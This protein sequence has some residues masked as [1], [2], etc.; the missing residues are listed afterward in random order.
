MTAPAF[1]QQGSASLE[2][3]FRQEI[4][5]V[6]MSWLDAL[7]RGD[8]RAV[9][10]YYLPGAP[11]INPAGV[12]RADTRDYVNRIER[13]HQRNLKLTAMIDRVQ[14]IGSDAG[15]AVG[16]F[17]STF[18]TNDSRS[19]TQGNWVQ[20]FEHAE[21]SGRSVYQALRKWAL[22]APPNMHK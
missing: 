9:A 1:G 7:N 2:E 18:G 19:Q 21:T 17:T 10:A 20:V 15:F 3:K 6:F 8:G 14:A 4:E 22:G 5:T 16:H 13:Q 11:A 12:V